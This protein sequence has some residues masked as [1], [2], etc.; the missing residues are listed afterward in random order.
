M[1]A[2]RRVWS[3][4][5]RSTRSEDATWLDRPMTSTFPPVAGYCFASAAA[6][7][8]NAGMLAPGRS[9]TPAEVP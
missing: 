5:T 9:R 3:V 2:Y 1:S 4:M 8:K 6:A 7:D